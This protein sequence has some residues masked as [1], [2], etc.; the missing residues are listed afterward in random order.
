MKVNAPMPIMADS[1]PKRG[2][3]FINCRPGPLSGGRLPAAPVGPDY[4][5]RTPRSPKTGTAKT[6]SPRPNP[7]KPR[8]NRCSWWNGGPPLTIRRSLPW[9]KWPCTPTWMC[10][11][12]KPASARPGR[13]GGWRAPPSGPRSMHRR[14]T[15]GARD[16]A[17]SAAAAPSPP[18]GGA[19][20]QL[21]A[22]GSAMPAWELDIFGGTPAQL[23]RPPPPISRPWW[24]TAA[25]S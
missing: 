5:H 3:I 2:K 15:R 17:K 8:T 24:R 25:M 12:P 7:A 11:W 13:P 6:S 16:P 10:A 18:P 1:S 21:M 22:G 14:F 19:L 4:A 9:W 20:R 23:S